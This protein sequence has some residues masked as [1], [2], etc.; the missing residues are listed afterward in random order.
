MET[1][2]YQK[3]VEKHT[4]KENKTSNALAAFI[5]GGLLGLLGNFLIDLYSYIFH[6]SKV[7]SSSLM[8]LTFIFVACLLTGLGVFDKLV[9]KGK[10]GLIIPI[11]GFAH[12]VQSAILDYKKE[13]PIYGFGSN[14]FKLAGSVILYGVVSAYIF[15]IIRYLIFEG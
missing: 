7:L 2:K 9:Q 13:G 8:L 3:I 12:S 5:T 10:M 1:R 14:V 4:P 11:T 6:I 15:A